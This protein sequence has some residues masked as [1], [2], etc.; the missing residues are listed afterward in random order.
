MCPCT[1]LPIPASAPP[2]ITPQLQPR[3][4][5][6]PDLSLLGITYRRI[7]LLAIG[8]SV[9]CDTH[10]ILRELERRFPVDGL[11][12]APTRSA[13]FAERSNKVFPYA[14]GCIPS[15]LPLMK[16][17][18]FVKDRGELSGL[19]GS[20]SQEWMYSADNKSQSYKKEDVDAARP[21]VRMPT[22]FPCGQIIN[23]PTKPGPSRCSESV[24][25]H[26]DASP[27]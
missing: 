27:R 14:A 10:L 19:V 8:N 22:A 3:I 24:R 25:I 6:R 11:D 18:R 15:D 7:P 17:P 26:G 21:K 16:D 4:L 12:I 20:T 23:R 9:Y 5:P 2:K 13:E 1:H